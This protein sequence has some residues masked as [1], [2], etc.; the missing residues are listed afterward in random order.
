[1]RT[2]QLPASE[3]EAI[4]AAN[5]V[6]RDRF[7]VVE[8]ASRGYY[9][10]SIGVPGANDRRRYDDASFLVWPDGIARFVSNTDPNGR[11][12]GYGTGANKG[13]ASLKTGIHLFGT[14]LH[15]G[16]PGFRQAEPFTVIRDGI[17]GDYPDTGM[18]AI[19]KH[20]GS[21]DEDDVGTTSSLGCQTMPPKQWK[22]Y[23]PLVYELLDEYENEMGNNDWNEWVPILPYILIDETERRKGNLLVS[24]RFLG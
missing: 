5:N 21:G 9:L 13:M 19:N 2:P 1:M 16:K 3:I 15:R 7:P 20:S 8:V 22:I 10:D 12:A 6:P 24:R 14:G 4:I 11:R 17:H 23:Q 18:H